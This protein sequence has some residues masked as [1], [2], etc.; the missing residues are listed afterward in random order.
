M[1]TTW[2]DDPKPGAACSVIAEVSQTHDGS[3][4]M[5]HAFIDAAAD[6]GADAI[7]FQT[8]IAAAE[9]TPSEPWRTRFS[10]Q[11]ETR[12]EY[13]KRMEFSPQQW[14]GLEKHA[15]ERDLHF[16]SSPFSLEALEL[17]TRVGVSAWKVASG[18]INN[19]P[20]LDAMSTTGLPVLLS[21]GMSPPEEIEQS[22]TRVR[23]HGAPVAVLQCSS[24]YPTPPELVG[25][26]LIPEFR[27]R[28]GCAVGLSDHSATIYPGLAAA[29]LGIEALEV[30]I[31]L[32]REMF[33]PD[34]VASI[35]TSELRQLVEGVRFIESMRAAPVD[36]ASLPESITSLRSIFMKSIVAAVD[37]S[38]GTVL[39]HEHI[40]AKKP[41]TGIPADEI[42]RIVGLR[43]RQSIQRDEL[44]SEEDLEEVIE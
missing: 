21:T 14:A 19:G 20:L 34:V 16:L 13:W 2:L 6:A 24:M 36:K 28:F 41:G 17:L 40:V 33:G 32:S 38:S 5:A 27:E 4:G 26:N 37:I 10:Q 39:R 7:K 11:D 35:T 31:T 18:E 9:T 15:R 3:L 25:I 42:E 12:Y 1:T 43:L 23:D 29:T 30:H 44:L 8:H 22:V